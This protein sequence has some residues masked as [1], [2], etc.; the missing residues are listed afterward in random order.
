MAAG[1]RR[2]DTFPSVARRG[3]NPCTA[4]EDVMRW[5]PPVLLLA[6]CGGGDAPADGEDTADLPAICEDAPVVTW[7]NF[8]AG[9]VKESCQPCHASTAAERHDAP[10]TV[11]FDTEHDVQ[12]WSAQILDIATGESPTMPPQGGVSD[13]DRYLLEVWLTCAE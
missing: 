6:A 1:A 5:F 9:F 7:D 8:G 12:L 4:R 2:S 13:D 11:V 10:D 3:S